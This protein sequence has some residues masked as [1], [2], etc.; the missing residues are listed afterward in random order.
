MPP[1]SDRIVSAL[2]KDELFFYGPY[3]LLRRGHWRLKYVGQIT[4]CLNLTIGVRP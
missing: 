4:G 3:W 1:E 2:P